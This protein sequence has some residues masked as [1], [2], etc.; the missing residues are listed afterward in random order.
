MNHLNN[1]YVPSSLEPKP[2]RLRRFARKAWDKFKTLLALVIFIGPSVAAGLSQCSADEE[3]VTAKNLAYAKGY[4]A[5]QARAGVEQ[6][7]F[8]RRPQ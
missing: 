3:L 5:A 8:C 6:E 2:E 4:C 7:E 1:A